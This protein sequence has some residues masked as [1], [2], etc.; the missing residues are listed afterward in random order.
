MLVVGPETRLS[1]RARL[2]VLLSCG[3]LFLELLTFPVGAQC[4]PKLYLT[5]VNSKGYVA[6][7]TLMASG[8]F[9]YRGN[10]SWTHLGW[11]TPR[12]KAFT[13]E[14]ANSDIMFLACGNG[15]AR[16][17]DGGRTW[18]ITTDWRVTEALDICL[19]PN[20]PL[21]VYLAT[22]YGMWSSKD[23]GQTWAEASAGIEKKYIQTVQV[24]RTNAGRVFAGTE[25]GLYLST[26]S[27]A[28][29][30]RVDSVQDAI[31]ELE[32]SPAAPAV[33]LAATQARGILLSNDSGRTWLAARSSL[34]QVPVYAVT[35]DP[36]NAQNL[37]AASWGAGV[38]V[39]SNAGKSWQRRHLGLPVRN[40]SAA[41]FDANQAGRLWVAT[42]EEGIFYSDDLGRSWQDAGLHGAMVFDL[43]FV[44]GQ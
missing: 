3:G 14:P 42:F 31:I 44:H 13:C 39:S 15:A 23:G 38:Y 34:A 4:Q 6:G 37:A 28:S 7:G 21:H 10:R 29:W 26:N 32:Q 2:K 22:A 43:V 25:G 36:F 17:R 8:L 12:A 19:D 35:F 30:S 16:S 11:N 18:R 24:D 5:A 9:L 20:A 40:L 41:V 33:W 27:A 1:L